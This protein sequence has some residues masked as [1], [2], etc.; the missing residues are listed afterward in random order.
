MEYLNSL[1]KTEKNTTATVEAINKTEA[2]E[3]K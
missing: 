3:N 1:N 2:T